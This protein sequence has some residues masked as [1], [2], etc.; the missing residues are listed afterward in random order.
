MAKL[1][2][3]YEENF[4]STLK[5]MG[6][7]KLIGVLHQKLSIMTHL[8]ISFLVKKVAGKAKNV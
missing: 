5:R 4:T 8:S 7:P 1:C 6:W 3:K 2:M